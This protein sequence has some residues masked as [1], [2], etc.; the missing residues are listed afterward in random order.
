MLKITS[1][2]GLWQDNISQIP[3]EQTGEAKDT[4]TG[5]Q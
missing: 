3:A 2:Q 4:V 5:L 1:T